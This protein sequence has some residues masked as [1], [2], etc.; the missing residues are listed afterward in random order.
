VVHAM[1][2]Y[3]AEA[4]FNIATNTL[5][6]AHGRQDALP[7]NWYPQIA[8]NRNAPRSLVPNQKHDF[9]P[10]FGFAY[11]LMKNTVIRGGY[12]IFYSSY[13]AGPLSIPNPGNNPPFF[14]QANYPTVS[15]IQPNPVVGNL[16]QGFPLDALSNPSLPSVFALDPNFSNPYVQHWQLSV[17]RELGWN[18]VWEV[19]YAGSKG[20]RLYEFRQANPVTPTSDPNANYA[21]LRPR[22]Y[23]GDFSLWC[24]CNSSTYHSLQTKIE[25]RFSNDLSFLTA[26]TYGKSIDEVS[27]ASLGFHGGGYARNWNHPEWEKGP[28]DFDQKFRFVNSFSYILPIGKGKRFL[29]GLNGVGNALIG[30]WELQGIQSATSGV[31]FTINASIGES[32]TNGDSEERP[33]RVVGVPLYPSNQSASEWF[34][35]AAFTATAFG[36]LGNS[37]RNIIYTAP[38]VSVDTS[39]FKDFALRERVKLQFRSEFFNMLNHPNF[40]SNSLNNNFDAPGAGAYSAAQPSRQIQFALKLIY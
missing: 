24:S 6:I 1:E 26:F 32:N 33:N 28:S 22:P 10:R 11:N 2:K 7:P 38:Q 20:T 3:N 9:G 36:T 14:E 15:A 30:G 17:Q 5:D 31:P 4:N 8:V 16:S 19:A 12:G 21:D 40:R 39:L 23:L 18:T 34:N 29:G 37:G 35:P 25:K 13:E 27:T